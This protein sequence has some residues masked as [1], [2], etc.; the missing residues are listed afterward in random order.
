MIAIASLAL[1]NILY[2]PF[3]N[4]LTV[5]IVAFG[6][7]TLISGLLGTGALSNLAAKLYNDPYKNR[8]FVDLDG[9]QIKDVT[10]TNKSNLVKAV[11]KTTPL[12]QN[13]W[14]T[15]QSTT[16]L[17]DGIGI[18][19][20]SEALLKDKIQQ[21]N[22]RLEKN[23]IPVIASIN[24]LANFKNINLTKIP[25]AVERYKTTQKIAQESLGSKLPLFTAKYLE[26]TQ[27]GSTYP[28]EKTDIG[29]V[30]VGVNHMLIS[31]IPTE[32]I[33]GNVLVP[34]EYLP[35][36]AAF[37][38]TSKVQIS[39]WGEFASKREKEDYLISNGRQILLVSPSESLSSFQTYTSEFDFQINTIFFIAYLVF[40][41]C[42]VFIITFVSRLNSES[43][44]EAMMLYSLGV[45]RTKI[46][47]IEFVQSLALVTTGFVLATVYS[48]LL[49]AF[50]SKTI[51]ANFLGNL[52]AQAS[53]YDVALPDFLFLAPPQKE[54]LWV[55]LAV[56]VCTC[57]GTII[58]QG[59]VFSKNVVET[60]KS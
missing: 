59:K 15:S 2:K 60:L 14:G 44:F 42:G 18:N 6:L 26:N 52:V 13:I 58:G 37:V 51:G 4:L 11:W 45:S 9:Q 19:F 17:Q 23:D 24:V 38:D 49:L 32:Q 47:V 10:K 46:F 55:F 20:Y 1:K 25:D 56:V 28:P 43:S 3:Q 33:S 40:A 36:F 54:I 12:E 48:Y 31:N 22:I 16:N 34:L 35:K 27:D 30:V 39:R 5:H 50:L 8:W 29:M 41:I 7:L 57:V 53:V 21:K